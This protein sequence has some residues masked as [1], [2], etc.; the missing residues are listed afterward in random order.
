M[1]LRTSRLLVSAIVLLGFSV[2]SFVTYTSSISHQST[3]SLQPGLAYD[4]PSTLNPSDSVT[5]T[6]QENSGMLVS[7]YVLSSA[8][9]AS[10]LAKNPFSYLSSVTNVASGGFSFTAIVQDTYYL[11]FD[12]GT[13]LANTVETVYALRSYTTHIAYRLYVGIFLL[14]AA[15]VDL[16]YA[17]RTSKRS[18]PT[19]SVSPSPPSPS[20]IASILCRVR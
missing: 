6:F 12:H 9:Y 5:V 4:I 1:E 13:G 15:G 16:Y 17:Y 10:Y 8:Q 3:F 20:P 2:F 7:F 11:F 14:V 18:R 19:P